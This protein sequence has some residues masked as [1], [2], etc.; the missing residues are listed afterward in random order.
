M[1]A[2]L[3]VH[4]GAAAAAA[5]AAPAPAPAAAAAPQWEV[6]SAAPT[7]V[8]GPEQAEQHGIMQGF[9]TGNYMKVGGTYYYSATELGFCKGIRWDS[10]TRAGLWSAPNSTGPWTRLVTLRNSTSMYSVCKDEAGKGVKNNV[11]WAPTL[12]FAPSGANGSTAVW[13]LFYHAGEAGRFQPGDGVVHA[14]STTGSIEGPYTELPGTAVPGKD[15]VVCNSH[16]FAAWKLRNGSWVGFRNNVPGVSPATVGPSH[17]G[18]LTPT[19]C[20]EQAKSFSVGLIAATEDGGR[21]VGGT[22]RY[23]D[24]NSVPFRFGPE[25]PQVASSHDNRFYFA[26]YDALEQPPTGGADTPTE[27]APSSLSAPLCTDKTRCD[28][29]GIAWSHDGTTWTA[30]ASTTLRVQLGGNHPCGQIRT[31]LGIVPEPEQCRGCYSVLWTGFS[32]VSNTMK[33][34]GWEPVCQAVIR[35]TNE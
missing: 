19:V 23:P 29:I 34:S 9:E 17:R 13:N 15:C 4:A 11:V 6:V 5:P 10:T 18:R 16:A 24:N 2:A 33:P 1:L 28:A 21:S 25:N 30:E 8:I 7:P 20:C 3:L 14:V 31:A 22:W 32:N 35:N 12:V 27:D 26:V